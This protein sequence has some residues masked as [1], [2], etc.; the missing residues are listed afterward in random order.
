MIEVRESTTSDLPFLREMLVQAAYWRPG[1]VQVDV[2]LALSRDDLKYLL[3]QWGR[4]G[5]T[6][7]VAERDGKPI[8]A[9]WY[10]L[11][12]EHVHSY[13]YVDDATP[14]IAIGVPADERGKGIGTAL[15]DHLIELARAR[16]IER[17]SLSVELDNPARRLYE[18]AGFRALSCSDSA[19]TMVLQLAG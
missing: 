4:P 5:D 17:L 10:R 2:E 6:G 15:L 11:W 1:E 14:E 18:R 19:A 13:G 9:A 16:R 3:A 8:G 12:T 7:V